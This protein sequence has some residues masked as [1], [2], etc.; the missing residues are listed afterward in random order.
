MFW[1]LDRWSETLNLKQRLPIKF[2]RMVRKIRRWG[3][4]IFLINLPKI[5][6]W[7]GLIIL[8]PPRIPL[9]LYEFITF[10]IG[11]DEKYQNKNETQRGSIYYSR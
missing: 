10:S 5:L 9:R 1:V 11:E 4:L 6:A 3:L 2:Q 7:K 8:L